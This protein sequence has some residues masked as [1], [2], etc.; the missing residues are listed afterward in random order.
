V[1]SFMQDKMALKYNCILMVKA[2]GS[3]N[4]MNSSTVC[5]LYLACYGP[6]LDL[7]NDIVSSTL[8]ICV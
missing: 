7:F 1:W 4:F 3:S 8:V 2:G 6:S 5:S